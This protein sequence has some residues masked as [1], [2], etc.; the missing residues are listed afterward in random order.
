[1]GTPTNSDLLREIKDTNKKVKEVKTIVL[2]NEARNLKIDA[3]SEY[4]KTRPDIKA[5][6]IKISR[7]VWVLIMKIVGFVGVLLTLITAAR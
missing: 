2:A 4:L 3:V 5:S 7:E 1:M 6:D